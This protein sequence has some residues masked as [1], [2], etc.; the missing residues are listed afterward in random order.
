MWKSKSVQLVIRRKCAKSHVT[1]RPTC[2]ALLFLF[3]VLPAYTAGPNCHFQSPPLFTLH[4]SRVLDHCR[5][6]GS[7]FDFS[8]HLLFVMRNF[9]SSPCIVAARPGWVRFAVLRL[10]GCT[11]MARFSSFLFPWRV[12]SGWYRRRCSGVW[13]PCPDVQQGGMSVVGTRDKQELVQAGPV[14]IEVIVDAE[15]LLIGPLNGV[16]ILVT[17]VPLQLLPLLDVCYCRLHD[18]SVS[19]LAFFFKGFIKKWT[20]GATLGPCC[21]FIASWSPIPFPHTSMYLG[22]Q[23]ML[24][25]IPSSCIFRRSLQVSWPEVIVYLL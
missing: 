2:W 10:S 25:Q 4:P 6:R 5:G 18:V 21:H 20:S 11:S 7:V 8:L 12:V 9:E 23:Q 22:T 17:P 16:V 3:S 15:R 19:S 1:F 24:Q 14:L 13:F